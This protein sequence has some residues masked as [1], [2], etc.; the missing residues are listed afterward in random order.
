MALDLGSGALLKLA[1]AGGPA[2]LWQRQLALGRHAFA[3]APYL[4]TTNSRLG[5]LINRISAAMGS[6]PAVAVAIAV[7][8]TVACANVSCIH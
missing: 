1:R 4:V 8:V 7:A 6:A 2:L 3:G 5:R